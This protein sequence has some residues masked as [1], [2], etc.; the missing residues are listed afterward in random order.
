MSDEYATPIDPIQ[1]QGQLTPNEKTMGMLCHLLSLSGVLGIP[2]ANILGPLILWIIK[3]DESAFIDDQGKESLNFQIFS[4]IVAIAAIAL[5]MIMT[6]V[7]AGLGICIAMPIW[8]GL[9]IAWLIFVIIACLEANKGNLYR[10]PVT[11]RLIK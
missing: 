7:T 8:I 3:K 6:V 11:L 5:G 1:T 2:F 4:T 9:G 10:Y